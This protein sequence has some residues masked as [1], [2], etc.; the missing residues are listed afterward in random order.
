ME[1]VG[2]GSSERVCLKGM[3]REKMGLMKTEITRKRRQR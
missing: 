1:S 3:W 2:R